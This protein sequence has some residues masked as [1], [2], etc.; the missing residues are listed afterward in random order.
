MTKPI[1]TLLLCLLTTLVMAQ[2]PTAPTTQPFGKVDMADLQLAKCDFEPDANAEVLFDKGRV[3]F[4]QVFNLVFERHRRIKIFNDNG[5]SEANIKIE[6]YGGARFEMISGLQAQT[7]NIVDGKPVITKLD[8]KL[9]YTKNIDKVRDEITFTLPEIKAGSVIEYK[10]TITTES[11]GNFPNWEFQDKMPVRYSEFDTEI[12]DMLY[13]REYPRITQQLTKNTKATESGAVSSGTNNLSFYIEKEQRGMSNI[14]SLSDEPYMSSYADN[15]QNLV[16]QLI[17]VKPIR[18]VARTYSDT[19]AKV[20]GALEDYDEFGGQLKKKLNGEEAIINKAKALKTDDAKIAYVFGEVKN[21]MKWNNIDRWYT[22]DGTYKAWEAKTG[23][24]A[25]INLI[26]YH[27]L[28]Q[29]GV[30][31]YPMVVSTR[32]HGKVQAFHTSLSQFNRAVVY[33][34]VD[35]AKYYVLDATGKYNL[36][37][38]IPAE[39]LNSSGLYIDKAENIYDIVYLKRDASV[40]QVVLI[41]AE[42]KSDGK[43]DGTVQ[44]NSPGYSKIAATKRYKTDGEKKNIDYLRD[45]DNNLK[46]S[47]IT[48]DNMEVDTLPLTQKINFNLELSGSDETYIYLTPNLFTSLKSNPFLNENRLTDIDFNYLRAYSINGLYKMPVGYKVDALPQS[49]SIVMPDKSI[50]FKRIVAEQ[51]GSIIVRYNIDF[52]KQLYSKADYVDFHEFMKKM[53]D[54]LNEKVVLKKS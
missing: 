17:S 16:F 2:A 28:K 1:T 44:I 26:L 30:E 10:Y 54:M 3:Y 32:E 15:V 5:R 12:P 40:R 31:A 49:G 18:G 22:N 45:G 20:G 50:V 9:I 53:I 6:Y 19:W 42:I 29:S 38:E 21:A 7:I 46:I 11:Y 33:V 13:Y 4:D 47:S 48:F 27:L 41:N 25:E 37:S 36:Y 24:S 35:S 39:L 8:K 43:L 52:K 51:E 14:H 34:P 23:N